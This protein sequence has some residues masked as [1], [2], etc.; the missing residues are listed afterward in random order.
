MGQKTKE[1]GKAE[2][3]NKFWLKIKEACFREIK[4]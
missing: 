1:K 2:L 4:F 3:Q